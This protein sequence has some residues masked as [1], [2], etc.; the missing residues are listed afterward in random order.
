M[1]TALAVLLA[2]GVMLSAGAREARAITLD[3][4]PASQDVA[5]GGPV[6]VTLAISG[7][8]DL[9]APS[10][11]TFDVDLTFDPG[12]LS[13][14]NAS[15]GDPVL[16]A[17]LGVG[18]V[19]SL[20]AGVVGT[21]NLFEVSLES[22]DDLN[23]GQAGAF[24]LAT[25]SFLAAGTGSAAI[26]LAVNALGDAA[27]AALEAEAVGASVRITGPVGVP[28]PA[29]LTLLGLGLVGVTLVG[30]RALA[31]RRRVGAL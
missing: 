26:G 30:R 6:T 9:V 12:R 8:G 27:G 11:G 2:A 1:R 31:R 10:L 19:K 18:S 5:L 17:Q 14:V 28:E 24:T 13:F 29:S 7:L 4:L 3:V 25:V 23:T 15:F 16:G 21:I 20:D 22:V